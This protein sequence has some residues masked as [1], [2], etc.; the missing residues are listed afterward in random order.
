MSYSVVIVAGGKGKRFGSSIPKQFLELNGK[1]ILFYT[2][3]KFAKAI[4]DIEI[5]L[6]LPENQIDTWKKIIKEKNFYI[7]HK[8]AIGGAERFHSVKNGLN[9]TTGSFVAIHDGVRPFVS[10]VLIKK[11]FELVKKY[12]AV[13]PA[14]KPTSSVRIIENEKNYAFPRKKIRLIQTPQF[15]ETQLIKKAIE[16]DYNENFTDDA[17][18]VENLGIPI[19]LFE[20][21]INNIKI[22]TPFDLEIAK[23]LLDGTTKLDTNNNT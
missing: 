15:F 8:I 21:E 2:I 20:G 6:V 11:G 18:V 4:K 3:E 1:P 19:Y 10:E 13:V 23:I 16:Q 9:L 22:T 17:T 5:I 12:K 14:I 7:N